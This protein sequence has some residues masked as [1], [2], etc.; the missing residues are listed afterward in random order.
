MVF[1][2]HMHVCAFG[3]SGVVL[4]RL[5][6]LSGVVLARLLRRQVLTQK[7]PRRRRLGRELQP[8]HAA[9][10]VR[11]G[12]RKGAVAGRRLRALGVQCKAEKKKSG[13]EEKRVGGK[14]RT[15]RSEA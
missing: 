9:Q 7:R 5:L 8:G 11:H 1:L 14:G 4:A 6:L 2:A 13:W 12:A 10:L 3:V 15:L